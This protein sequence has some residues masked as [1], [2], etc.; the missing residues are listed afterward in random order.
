M[1]QMQGTAGG[2]ARK[3]AVDSVVRRLSPPTPPT[4]YATAPPDP[5]QVLP[6]G[7]AWAV[8]LALAGMS[9]LA[10]ITY[11]YKWMAIWGGLSA[12]AFIGLAIAQQFNTREVPLDPMEA[13]P[14]YA[15]E[16]N[17]IRSLV[18]IDFDKVVETG[19]VAGTLFEGPDQMWAKGAAGEVHTSRLLQ[20][21]LD[22]T[23]TVWDDLMIYK[24]DM[25]VANIDHLV[26]NERGGIMVDTKVWNQKLEFATTSLG[27]VIP[28]ESFAAGAVSTCIFEASS[29]PGTPRAI[30][31]AV[32]GSSAKQIPNGVKGVDFYYDRFDNDGAALRAPM[33]VVFVPQSAIAETIKTLDRV[34]PD[35]QR[36]RLSG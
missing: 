25:T 36:I 23:Y 33:P 18:E 12:L 30:V 22:D 7:W 20:Q 6:G 5:T 32:G 14:E 13:Y 3:E 9:F 16:V 15:A 11:D 27:T 21:G 29:L 28:K 4:K 31:F 35:G 17:K 24:G 10:L 19:N 34:L 1:A 2:S 26:T 8:V